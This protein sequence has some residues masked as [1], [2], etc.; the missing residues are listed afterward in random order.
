[1]QS[2]HDSCFM[3]FFALLYY[4]LLLLCPRWHKN[5]FVGVIAFNECVKISV[6]PLVCS[7]SV[8][9]VLLSDDQLIAEILLLQ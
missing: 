5:T 4:M 9:F 7:L 6:S 8:S 3:F 1:M 2:F